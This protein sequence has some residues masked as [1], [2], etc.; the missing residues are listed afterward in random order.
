LNYTLPGIFL[1]DGKEKNSEVYFKKATPLV[2]EAFTESKT[3]LP[4]F[5]SQTSTEPNFSQQKKHFPM[6]S[7]SHQ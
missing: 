5:N 7:Y 3:N 6:G 4:G 2:A 1:T